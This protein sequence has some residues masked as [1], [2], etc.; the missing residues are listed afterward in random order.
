[1]QVKLPISEQMAEIRDFVPHRVATEFQDEAGKMLRGLPADLVQRVPSKEELL[2]EFGP[3]E[4]AAL[5]ALKEGEYDE[6]LKLLQ[7]EYVGRKVA[8]SGVDI[9]S[10]HEANLVKVTGMVLRIGDAEAS[11]EMILDLPHEDVLFLLEEI[12]K[13]WDEQR[14]KKS[15]ARP[16]N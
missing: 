13:V 12:E 8:A 4:M 9:G 7:Q 2:A 5:D 1:M 11:R 10:A 3:E 15:S 14:K 6:R 16:V